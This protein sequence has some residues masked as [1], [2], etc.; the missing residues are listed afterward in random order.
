MYEKTLSILQSNPDTAD[1]TSKVESYRGGCTAEVRRS[2]EERLFHRKL[3][4][5]VGTNALELGVDQVSITIIGVVISQTLRNT[6]H[7]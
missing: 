4:A 2:I 7:C 1:L 5:V 3:F 6:C